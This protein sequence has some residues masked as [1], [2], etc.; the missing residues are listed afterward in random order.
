MQNR[1]FYFYTSLATLIITLIT[2]VIAFFTPPYSGPFCKA[3]KCYEYPYSDIASRFP[4]D[5]YWIYPAMILIVAYVALLSSIHQYASEDK[6]IYSRVGFGFALITAT[7]F[8]IDFF[9]K[10]PLFNP[11]Y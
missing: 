10:F 4:R 7:V 6:K 1:R 3:E 11:V 5:Y 8:L 2:F 9:C